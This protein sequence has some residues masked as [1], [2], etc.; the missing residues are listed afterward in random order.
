V[1]NDGTVDVGKGK[2]LRLDP[3]ARLKPQKFDR[4]EHD[5]LYNWSKLRSQYLAEANEAS[6]RTIV[7][8]RGGWYGSGWYWNPY[9]DTWSYVPGDGLFMSPF[10][11]GFY[12]PAYWYY[13][14]PVYYYGYGPGRVWRGGGGWRHPVGGSNGGT[15]TPPPA[16]G[17]SGVQ[18]G[19]PGRTAAPAPAMRAP[20]APAM[21]SPAPAMGGGGVRFGRGR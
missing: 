5:A 4:D 18:F 1:E 12:S 10:G 7:V 13:N 8:N 11:F 9:F 20:S 21:R 15:R 17:G 19:S 16:V 14:R 3:N 6:V 2:Q